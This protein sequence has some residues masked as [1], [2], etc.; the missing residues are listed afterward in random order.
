MSFASGSWSNRERKGEGIE[1]GEKK[2]KEKGWHG[3]FCS[4]VM[5]IWWGGFVLDGRNQLVSR[6]TIESDELRWGGFNRG[7]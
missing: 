5:I 2:K 1:K 3:W 6:Y 4:L 7:V